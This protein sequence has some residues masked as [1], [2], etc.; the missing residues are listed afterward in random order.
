MT[1]L[2]KKITC[3]KDYLQ[4]G[5]SKIPTQSN[6]SFIVLGVREWIFQ[7]FLLKSHNSTA[8]TQWKMTTPEK[9]LTC[10]EDYV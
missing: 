1:T 9:K 10:S 5:F 3:P 7:L 2:K 4:E 6:I 8:I